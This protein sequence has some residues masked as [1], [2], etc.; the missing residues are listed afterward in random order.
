MSR[1]MVRIGGR[2]VSRASES[3]EPSRAYIKE[4]GMREKITLLSLSLPLSRPGDF[5]QQKT[6]G[7]LLL[8]R[9]FHGDSAI[10]HT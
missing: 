10:Q 3:F 7:E 5:R 6:S 8:F 9:P 2:F 4:E 1:P